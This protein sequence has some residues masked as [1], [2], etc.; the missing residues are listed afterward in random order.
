MCSRRK[1]KYES[2]HFKRQL[3]KLEWSMNYNGAE[4]ES[5][6]SREGWTTH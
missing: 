2:S 6:W 1:S 5:G 4:I 3:K